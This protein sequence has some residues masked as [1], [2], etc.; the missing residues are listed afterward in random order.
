LYLAFVIENSENSECRQTA[1]IEHYQLIWQ[2]FV[3]LKQFNI[4]PNY[5]VKDGIRHQKSCLPSTEKY[6]WTFIQPANSILFAS[7]I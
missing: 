7:V 1:M 2:Y 4:H 6:A 5:R 3:I